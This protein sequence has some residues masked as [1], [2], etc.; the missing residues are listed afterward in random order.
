[1]LSLVLLFRTIYFGVSSKSSEV[2]ILKLEPRN[3]IPPTKLLS[4]LTMGRNDNYMGNFLWRLSTI[5]NNHARNI[6]Y[7]GTE[8][9]IEILV[10]DWGSETPIFSALDLTRDA[11]KLCKFLITPPV[12]A[13]SYDKDGTFAAV[14]TLNALARRASGKYLLFADSDVF[15]PLD[16]MTKL[17]YFLRQDQVDNYPLDK[18]FF[19]GSKF[20][21]PYNLVKQ[22]PKLETIDEDIEKNWQS[23]ATEMVSKEK[24]M[25]SGVTLL[26]SRDMWLESGGMDEKLIYWGWSDIEWNLRLQSKYKWDTME[27]HGMRMFHLEHY[28]D[29]HNNDQ[30]EN[31]RIM[32]PTITPTTFVV[33]PPNWG[34]IEH[35]LKF[36]DGNGVET[37]TE[38]KKLPDCFPEYLEGIL[39]ASAEELMKPRSFFKDVG[40]N[41]P[42]SINLSFDS[43]QKLQGLFENSSPKTIL[44]VGS[45]LGSS[46]NYFASLPGAT[47]VFALDVWD[48]KFTSPEIRKSTPDV[49]LNNLFEQFLA[50]C[51]ANGVSSKIYP[52]KLSTEVAA[53]YFTSLLLKFDVIFFNDQEHEF[54][55]VKDLALLRPFLSP[56]GLIC[57]NN[58]SKQS[59][60]KNVAKGIVSFAAEHGL[61]V[62]AEDNFWMLLPKS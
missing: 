35:D 36:V 26:M 24:F 30:V 16:A 27:S 47:K 55:I 12:V 4:I 25:G 54:D 31:P 44:D 37:N 51:K 50:N 21:I 29:R 61:N 33:N 39:P 56:L 10:N 53:R 43:Q 52:I 3:P 8:S 57:G 46:V 18:S 45:V 59:E 41:L 62:Y 34:L 40:S 20:H 17:L 14:C 58:W 22:S 32:N 1:M 11:K 5:L 48:C 9:E 2:T 7:L 6:T 42:A 13:K 23:Y 49:I 60:P 19:W 15:V 28:A 38:N